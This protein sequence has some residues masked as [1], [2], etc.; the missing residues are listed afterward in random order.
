MAHLIGPDP[1][2]RDLGYTVTEAAGYNEALLAINSAAEFDCVVSDVVMSGGDG[3][4]LAAAVRALAPR[5]PFM[6]MT[7]RSDVNRLT[8]EMVLQ[9]PFTTDDLAKAVAGLIDRAAR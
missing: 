3:L 9:K 5:I 2:S 7:G 1:S 8:G 4:A 6:F